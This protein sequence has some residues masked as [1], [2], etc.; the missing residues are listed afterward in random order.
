VIGKYISINSQDRTWWV[1]SPKRYEYNVQLSTRFR[2]I[3]SISVGK[4]IIPDEIIQLSDPVKTSFNYDFTMAFPYLILRIDE[5]NDIYDGTNE[6]VKKGF[7]KLVFYK[8]YKG[9]NGRGYVILKPEQKEKKYFYP[10]PLATINKLSISL[11]KPSGQLLNKSV[12]SYK[13][14]SVVYDVAKP[15]FYKVTT[16]VFFDRNEFYIGDTVIFKNFSMS[17]ESLLQNTNDIASFNEFINRSEGHDVIELGTANASG[18]FNSFYIQCIGSFDGMLG[19]FVIDSSIVS[20]LNNYNSAITPF[21]NGS[22]MNLSLQNSISMKIDMIVDD[23]K[24]LDAQRVF[25]F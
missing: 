20:C 14:L 4:V 19:N 8:S 6:V 3:D 18:Y 10:A 25:N 13:I 12:D 2:N 5:F 17:R 21:V 23:A 1:D 24:I 16:N 15:N 7:C 11:L 22:I 9:Q